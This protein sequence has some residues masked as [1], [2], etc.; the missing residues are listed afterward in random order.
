MLHGGHGSWLH[1]IRNI[2]ALGQRHTLLIPD[3][4]GFGDSDELAIEAHADDRLQ[5]LVDAV[6]G[7]LDALVGRRAAMFSSVGASRDPVYGRPPG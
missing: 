6:I 3:L 4:P 5:R 7:S 1:W 2:D